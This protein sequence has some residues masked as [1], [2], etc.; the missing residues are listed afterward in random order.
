MKKYLKLLMIAIF[1]S[2]SFAFV[3]CGND[4]EPDN[5]STGNTNYAKYDLVGSWESVVVT[6]IP[7]LDNF[8]RKSYARFYEDGTYI[9]VNIQ[10]GLENVII[11]GTWKV[12]G[13]KFTTTSFGTSVTYEF[14]DYTK[15][16]FRVKLGNTDGFVR[17]DRI[18]DWVIDQ[19]L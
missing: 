19:Y 15:N 14:I 18:D 13:N 10:E 7:G 1:T 9:G 16:S 4:D 12:S 6:E 2:M 8:N 5:G 17:W 3:A 11:R